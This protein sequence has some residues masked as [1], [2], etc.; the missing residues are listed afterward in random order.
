MQEMQGM[1]VQSLGQEDPLEEE[2]ATHSSILAWGIPWTE[3]PGGLQSMGPQECQIQSSNSR[4]T[5][6][7]SLAPGVTQRGCSHTIGLNFQISE[8]HKQTFQGKQQHLHCLRNIP[9]SKLL[10]LKSTT[11]Q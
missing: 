10:F 2:I 6:N 4:R 5:T 7:N 9:I 11:S 8:S 3:E 1:W